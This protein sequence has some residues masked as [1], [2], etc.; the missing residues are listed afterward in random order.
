MST[1]K[2]IDERINEIAQNHT[3][4]FDFPA[5][6]TIVA[7]ALGLELDEVTEDLYEQYIAAFWEATRRG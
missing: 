1:T 4:S 2:N 6:R 5:S 7:Q 3:A